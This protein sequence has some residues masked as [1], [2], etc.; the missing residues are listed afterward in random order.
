MTNQFTIQSAEN[1]KWRRNLQECKVNQKEKKFFEL[2]KMKSFFIF[3]ET[4]I[5]LSAESKATIN[6]AIEIV[7]KF[8]FINGVFPRV[9]ETRNTRWLYFS[10]NYPKVKPVIKIFKINCLWILNATRLLVVFSFHLEAGHEVIVIECWVD[11]TF[12]RHF[13]DNLIK[14]ADWE[15]RELC[16]QLLSTDAT[17]RWSFATLLDCFEHDNI[18]A[19]RSSLCWL[20]S[21]CSGCFWF[22]L[23]R[24]HGWWACSS[25]VIF[26]CLITSVDD[27]HVMRADFVDALDGMNF[28]NH[29]WFDVSLLTN[30]TDNSSVSVQHYCWARWW[31]AFFNPQVSIDLTWKIIQKLRLRFRINHDGDLTGFILKR[32]SDL[33]WGMFNVSDDTNSCEHFIFKSPHFEDVIFLKENLFNEDWQSSL[34]IEQR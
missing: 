9:C 11:V 6:W 18:F 12:S 8:L 19:L 23:R 30:C 26:F 3:K 20:C 4:W 29:D 28:I 2:I 13:I 22:A 33:C 7:F 17:F 34:K 25:L 1:M 15:I 5:H 24:F 31:I 14:F 27:F 32:I 16:I 21:E 10:I